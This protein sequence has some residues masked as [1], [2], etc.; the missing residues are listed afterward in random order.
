M[1]LQRNV[2]FG[3]VFP[4]LNH[5]SL[6]GKSTV[7]CDFQN[8]DGHYPTL[9][10]SI[11]YQTTSGFLLFSPSHFGGYTFGKTNGMEPWTNHSFSIGNIIWINRS[12]WSMCHVSLTRGVKSSVVFDE[13]MARAMDKFIPW[14][15]LHLSQEICVHLQGSRGSWQIQSGGSHLEVFGMRDPWGPP[16]DRC[17]M[18]QLSFLVPFNRW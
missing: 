8:H 5:I 11:H 9:I 4:L 7:W 3:L 13:T 6:Q 17:H 15:W 1:I 12:I 14:I 2:I 10:K 16:G 18:Y